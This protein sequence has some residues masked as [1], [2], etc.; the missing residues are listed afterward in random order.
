MLWSSVTLMWVSPLF[1]WLNQDY[2]HPEFVW[3]ITIGE[4]FFGPESLI[5]G[6]TIIGIAAGIF[7]WRHRQRGHRVVTRVTRHSYW[8]LGAAGLL[9]AV[10]IVLLKFWGGMNSVHAHILVCTVLAVL[11]MWQI[12]WQWKLPSVV[13]ALV[14]GAVMAIF[15]F[16]FYLVVYPDIID[17]WWIKEALWGIYIG[18]VPLEEILWGACNAMYLGPVIRYC[19]DQSFEHETLAEALEAGLEEKIKR[20]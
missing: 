6:F 14:L 3:K 20:L 1:E 4:F 11:V 13:T 18:K 19:M 7:D 16:A 12:Q 15:Y 9:A 2:W 5:L 17:D 10:P 8:R